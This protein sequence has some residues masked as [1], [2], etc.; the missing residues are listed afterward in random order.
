MKFVHNTTCS[1]VA[2]PT[3]ASLDVSTCHELPGLFPQPKLSSQ[4]SSTGLSLLPQL[5]TGVEQRKTLCAILSKHQDT[6]R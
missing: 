3:T 4:R 2:S 5:K 6:S 1:N